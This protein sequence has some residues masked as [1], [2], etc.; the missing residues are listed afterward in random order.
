MK[1][2]IQSQKVVLFFPHLVPALCRQAEVPTNKNKK[3]MKPTRS[4]IGDTLYTQYV[5][6]Q[7][8]Q[9][10]EWT[11]RRKMK[12]YVLASLKQKDHPKVRKGARRDIDAKLDGVIIWM[13]KIGLV[14]QEFARMDGLH[15]PSCLLD[16]FRLTPTHQDEEAIPK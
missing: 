4:I 7:Q 1:L 12:M 15:T 2:F 13:Q 9:I 5:E 8:K 3:Y 11:E 6:L 16:M 10:T 14:L